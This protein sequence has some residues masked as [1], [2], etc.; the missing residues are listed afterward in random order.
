MFPEIAPAQQMRVVEA[1]A[2]F[3][4]DGVRRAA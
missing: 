1:I 2:T 4:Q 3:V